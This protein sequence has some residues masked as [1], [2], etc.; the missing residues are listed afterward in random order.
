MKHQATEP[1]AVAAYFGRCAE[2]DREHAV[3][4]QTFTQAKGWKT[5][6]IRKRVSASWLRKLRSEGVT[7]VALA[8]QGRCADFS[9]ME[10][11]RSPR[12]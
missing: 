9:I 4:A 6:P 7:H 8:S 11:L 10:L 2:P 3:I 1:P 5:Y 12:S